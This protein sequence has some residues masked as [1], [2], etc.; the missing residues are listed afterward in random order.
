MSGKDGEKVSQY[1]KESLI[2]FRRNVPTRISSHEKVLSMFYK[3]K[4]MPQEIDVG[5]LP[6]NKIGFNGSVKNS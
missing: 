1:A 4:T 3:D 5:F 6:G 2:K